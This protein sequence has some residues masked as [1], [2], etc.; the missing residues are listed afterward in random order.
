MVDTNILKSITFFENF[1]DEQMQILGDLCELRAVKAGE[2][3]LEQGNLNTDLFFL[4]DGTVSVS[5]DGNVITEV[6]GDGEAFGEMSIASHSLT[7][8]SVKTVSDCSFVYLDFNIIAKIDGVVVESILKNFY[9]SISEILANKL[10]A[11]NEI[12]KFY[13]AKY[14]PAK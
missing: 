14:A 5:L 2:V 12:A 8:A 4:I 13:R 11:T 3:V 10:I 6:T 9:R 7:T 1:P